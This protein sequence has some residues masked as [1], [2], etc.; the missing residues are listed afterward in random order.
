MSSTTT[1]KCMTLGVAMCSG[2]VACA[3]T[4]PSPISTAVRTEVPSVP[5]FVADPEG[6]GGLASAGAF[7]YEIWGYRWTT[8]LDSDVLSQSYDR[9]GRGG[10]YSQGTF[11][12]IGLIVRFDG[13]IP[14][15]IPDPILVDPKGR[16]TSQASARWSARDGMTPEVLSHGNSRN[17]TLV[18][19]LPP[20][21]GAVYQLKV[22]DERGETHDIPITL[23][24]FNAERHHD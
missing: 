4:Q 12:L 13:A 3:P 21:P 20:E 19:E 24:P 9:P 8:I 16:E 18:F 15:L 7:K 22:G 5:K 6:F 10:P 2:V 17:F 23:P 11:L 1:V 14:A